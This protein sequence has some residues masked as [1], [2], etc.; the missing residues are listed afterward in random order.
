MALFGVF[1]VPEGKFWFVIFELDFEEFGVCGPFWEEVEDK[2]GW[3]GESRLAANATN[4]VRG[5]YDACVDEVGGEELDLGSFDVLPNGAS[6]DVFELFGLVT[7]V[8]RK[9]GVIFNERWS[10]FG[11]FDDDICEHGDII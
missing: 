7:K 4:E 1:V 10:D 11:T 8:S 5:G 9:F 2:L 3:E 6:K